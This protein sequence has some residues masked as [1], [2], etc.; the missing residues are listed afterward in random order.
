MPIMEVRLVQRYAGQLSIMG[1]NYLSS[2]VPATVTH[3]FALA[4]AMGFAPSTTTLT[5]GTVG[6]LLQA[7]QHTGVEFISASIRDV[8]S[9]V[10]FY[11]SPFLVNTNG[12]RGGYAGVAP[13]LAIAFTSTKTRT[14]IRRGQRRMVGIRENDIVGSGAVE[15]SYLAGPLSDLAAEMSATI[16]YDDEG[17]TLSYSPVIVGKERYVVPDSNPPRYAYRYWKDDEP[18]QL[19]N[20]M[21]SIVWTPQDFVTSQ[22]SRK[23]NRGA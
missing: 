10:D 23:R 18:K 17:N 22:N 1:F 2:G 19:Q 11:E 8:Y 3:S 4:S 14:D 15:S 9:N 5:A 16:Q 21:A 20:L 6:G 12:T 13:F 7:A